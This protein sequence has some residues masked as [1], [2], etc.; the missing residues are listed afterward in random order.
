MADLKKQWC[1][2]WH[3]NCFGFHASN[4]LTSKRR[5]LSSTSTIQKSHLQ[6]LV[7]GE[8]FIIESGEVSSGQLVQHDTFS[9]RV[10]LKMSSGLKRWISSGAV[11]T[12]HGQTYKPPVARKGKASDSEVHDCRWISSVRA[13]REPGLEALGN[14]YNERM[15]V[16]PCWFEEWGDYMSYFQIF[17]APVRRGWCTMMHGQV[18][19]VHG[20]F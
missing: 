6:N 1:V 5:R 8:V 7:V 15:Y 19:W 18:L 20:T 13:P 11:I 16:E 10:Q 14:S 3:N 2:N 9:S 17:I 4:E 12:R